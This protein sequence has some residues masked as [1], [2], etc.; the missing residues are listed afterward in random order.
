MSN[1]V[2]PEEVLSQ[3]DLS[4]NMTAADFGCG[5]GGWVLPLAEILEEGIV[6]AIDVQ[7]SA[8]SALQNRAKMFSFNNIK[9]ILANV[10]LRIDRLPNKS[11]DLVLLTNLLFQVEN[12]QAVLEEAKRVLKPQGRLLIVDWVKQVSFGPPNI[13]NKD[14]IITF[15]QEGGFVLKEDSLAGSYHF[16]LLFEVN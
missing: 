8:L 14:E 10:E 12:K 16:C 7:S 1:F 9:P 15:C 3:L 6:F 13:L 4:P 11:C 5:A 2:N